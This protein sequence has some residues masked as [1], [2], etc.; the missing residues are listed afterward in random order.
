MPKIKIEI[1]VDE[2]YCFDCPFIDWGKYTA[3]DVDLIYDG[4]GR[5]RCQACKDAEVKE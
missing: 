5:I 4:E 3:F 2:K 1:E